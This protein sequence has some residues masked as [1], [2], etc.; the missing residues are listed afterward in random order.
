MIRVIADATDDL[1]AISRRYVN[2]YDA[3]ICLLRRCLAT[4]LGRLKLKDIHTIQ[5]EMDGRAIV[6][7]LKAEPEP[8]ATGHPMNHSS[9]H[10]QRK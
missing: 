2:P 3:V 7:P 8:P 10:P 4:D 1:P 9:N 5:K 6:L